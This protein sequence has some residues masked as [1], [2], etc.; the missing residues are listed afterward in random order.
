MKH[1]YW[2]LAIIVATSIWIASSIILIGAYI[3]P[4]FERQT[5][6]LVSRVGTQFVGKEELRSLEIARHS[7]EKRLGTIGG[8]LFG[9]AFGALAMR[10]KSRLLD[11]SSASD[12]LK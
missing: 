9:F 12:T 7:A 2:P 1:L 8:V 5:A 11:V 4:R 6:E 10:F 3:Q